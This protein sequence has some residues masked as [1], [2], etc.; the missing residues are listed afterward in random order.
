MT[1]SM[2]GVVESTVAT[3]PSAETRREREQRAEVPNGLARKMIV[4]IRIGLPLVICLALTF[5]F[6]KLERRGAVGESSWGFV[7]SPFLLV[8]VLFVLHCFLEW[9]TGDCA[10]LESTGLACSM[11]ISGCLLTLRLVARESLSVLFVL[12]PTQVTL[13]VIMIGKFTGTAS[14]HQPISRRERSQWHYR[15]WKK[16][17][18]ALEGMMYSGALFTLG[19]V[20]LRVDGAINASWLVVLAWPVILVI[21]CGLAALALMCLVAG[22]I[23]KV[24]GSEFDSDSSDD[25]DHRFTSAT[26]HTHLVGVLG[27]VASG[28]LI[29][30]LFAACAFYSTLS[31]LRV[32]SD[33][34]RLDDGGIDFEIF[35]RWYPNAN[36]T[37]NSL[38]GEVFV[39]IILAAFLAFCWVV[40]LELWIVPS[41]ER[42]SMEEEE[43]AAAAML[44]NQRKSTNGCISCRM[45]VDRIIQLDKPNV[46]I[47]VLNDDSQEKNSSIQSCSVCFSRSPNAV[48]YPCGHSG[49]CYD[50]A[51]QWLDNCE[52][53]CGDRDN[54]EYVVLQKQSATWFKFVEI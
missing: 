32:L 25:G 11:L 34:P 33:T 19:L 44:A 48:F 38:F 18:S 28:V 47:N 29:L 45:T 15:N 46:Q 31:L 52:S 5:V 41:L 53:K 1:W 16:Q 49:V 10:G 54:S 22:W 35:N 23:L 30:A 9:M 13:A 40:A 14:H 26:S 8:L 39:P 21:L 51:T 42:A 50:C 43:A 36:S 27:I 17:G 37:T 6:L 4:G 3:T 12:G 2:T 7:L 24:V 20:A